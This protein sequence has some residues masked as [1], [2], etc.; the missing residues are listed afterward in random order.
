MRSE[1]SRIHL[2]HSHF[3]FTKTQ[4]LAATKQWLIW[5]KQKTAANSPLLFLRTGFI[6]YRNQQISSS[7]WQRTKRSSVHKTPWRP[8]WTFF[9]AGTY[10]SAGNSPS[11]TKL[12]LT[13]LVKACKCLKKVALFLV[14]ATRS[15]QAALLGSGHHRFKFWYSPLLRA[16]PE[17]I[18]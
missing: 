8:L 12:K 10:F 17:C 18:L 11:K 14:D 5:C 7:W 16:K 4:G 3:A 6:H 15:P 9:E 2:D 13:G 1:V